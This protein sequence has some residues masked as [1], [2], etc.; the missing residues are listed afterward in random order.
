MENQ[1]PTPRGLDNF[2]SIVKRCGKD[3][4]RCFTDLN[5]EEQLAYLA[6]MNEEELRTFCQQLSVTIRTL[7]EFFHISCLFDDE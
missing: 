2:Y 1:Y 4:E 3:V 7:A 5:D 6:K